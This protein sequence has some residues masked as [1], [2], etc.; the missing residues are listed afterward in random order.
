LPLLSQAAANPASPDPA[1]RRVAIA[2]VASAVAVATFVFDLEMPLGVAAAMPYVLLV[3]LSLRLPGAAATW[4]A[5]GIATLLALL[6]LGIDL[7]DP[8]QELWKGLVN[9]AMCILV[10]GMTAALG[11]AYK[12][13]RDR[14]LVEQ[15]AA[16]RAEQLASLGEMAAGIAHELGT[17]LAA[18][19]GRLEM[20]EQTLA[21]G[22]SDPEQIRRTIRIVARLGER[23]TRIVRAVR[24]LAR[25]AWEDPFVDVRVEQIV[26]DVLEVAAERL[27]KRGVEVRVTPFDEDLRI[28][29]REAHISQ[30]LLN[31]VTNAADAI[32]DLPERWI[33]IDVARQAD[34]VVIAVTDSGDGIPD[35][36]RAR[37]MQPFFTTK[38]AGQGT[39]F[40]LSISR[41]FV[42]AH[43]GTLSVDGAS[44]HTRFV[45]TLPARR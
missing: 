19:Q 32:Q 14:L 24:S 17:P 25:D 28:P 38:P 9:R 39:G 21:A 37:V 33:R 27:R 45:V 23:M 35:E 2:G 42:E 18:L 43:S 26:R 22:G 40:G 12:R 20:L 5:A 29:C 16:L 11:V 30:V 13:S 36:I 15:A 8:Q 1:P 4:L 41:A 34:T 31:L 3:L 6:G 10:F 7:Q 44:P